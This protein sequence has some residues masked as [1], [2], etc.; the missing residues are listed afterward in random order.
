MSPSWRTGV[1]SDMELCPDYS[2]LRKKMYK[3]NG[4]AGEPAI[5]I[6]HLRDGVLFRVLC[7]GRSQ[8]RPHEAL[9]GAA[10]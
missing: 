10:A 8:N 7:R 6:G 1:V 2:V 3:W 4:C 5:R 9:R